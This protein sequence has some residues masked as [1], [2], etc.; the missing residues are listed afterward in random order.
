MSGASH[1]ENVY[2]TRRVDQ[3]SWYRPHLDLSL[4]LIQEALPERNGSIIDVGGGA[5]TLVDDLIGAGYQGVSVL[6][7]SAAALQIA[8]QRLSSQAAHVRWL[9]GDVTTYPFESSC[10]DLWHDR[11]AFHFLT[12]AEERATYVRQVAR[13]VKPGGHVIVATFG[14]QGPTRCSGLDVVRYSAP[15]LHEQFGAQFELIRSAIEVHH[16]PG[17]TEQQ[18]V[19]CLYRLSAA[20]SS[21]GV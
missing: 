19:Y 17:G 9:V 18:F 3:V 10:F 6:D 7:L 13:A 5:S 8:Q 15:A 1:W 2:R 11:A 20:G 14:P 21:R 12:Q 16:T 4:Q